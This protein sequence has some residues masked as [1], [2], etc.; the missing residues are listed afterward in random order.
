MEAGK[1]PGKNNENTKKKHNDSAEIKEYYFDLYQYVKNCKSISF[2]IIQ[3][4]EF[5]NFMKNT[6]KSR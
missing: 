3:E 1:I 5:G 6:S 4:N 2:E